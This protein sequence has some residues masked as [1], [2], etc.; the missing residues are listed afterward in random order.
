MSRRRSRSAAGGVSVAGSARRSSGLDSRTV[1][2][3]GARH[4]DASPAVVRSAGLRW[5]VDA[6]PESPDR[7][8]PV[9]DGRPR[10]T[11][12]DEP[13]AVATGFGAVWVANAGIGS[14][15]RFDLGTVRARRSSSTTSPSR[16][17]PA[18]ARS[19]SRASSAACVIRIDPK[20]TPGDEDDP[21][22]EPADRRRRRRRPRLGR[23][24][25]LRRSRSRCTR[26]RTAYPRM[27]R[28]ELNAEQRRAVEA[29]RGPV[30][31]LAG[32]GLGQD[33]DDHAADRAPGRDGSVRRRRRSSRSR[34]PTRPP[35]R[36]ARGWRRS[37]SPASARARSTPLRSSQLRY[38]AAGRRRADPRLEGADRSGRSRTRSRSRSGSGPAGDL[39]TEIEW[40]KNRRVPP[41][42][43]P[44]GA[45]RPRAADPAR[46]DGARVRASTRSGS[47]QRG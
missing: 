27:R 20:T 3:L 8:R 9:R 47:A 16:S 4:R 32:A 41:R 15:T 19:G 7:G 18:P 10:E 44:R 45:R 31:I 5:T 35:A 29:V 38:F 17:P 33:D 40:A 26:R 36:C 2:R 34:S 23:D 14:V 6:E 24:R 28:M 39:A 22:R 37:A 13:V 1:E 46:P 42:R 30:C 43:L 21:A 25:S 11:V 12:G